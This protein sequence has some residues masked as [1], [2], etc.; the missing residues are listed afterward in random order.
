MS[1]PSVERVP[2]CR[3]PKRRLF[4]SRAGCK[5]KEQGFSLVE[6]MVVILIMG[7]L[8][9]FVAPSMH[10][11][12]F[13]AADIKAQAL[14]KSAANIVAGA[15]A[16][17][18]TYQMMQPNQLGC[19]PI[20]NCAPGNP[21]QWR[22]DGM[23]WVNYGNTGPT[24][25]SLPG[26]AFSST[27]ANTVTNPLPNDANAGNGSATPGVVSF[28]TWNSRGDGGL[29]TASAVAVTAGQPSNNCWFIVLHSAGGP[30][31]FGYFDAPCNNFGTCWQET[32]P[33]NR[34]TGC[35]YEGYSVEYDG[36]SGQ[37]SGTFPQDPKA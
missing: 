16:Q 3:V 24:D 19:A 35:S 5:S 13:E 25:T 7:I 34:P 18:G 8:M 12:S 20:A 10:G 4:G 26:I 30:D 22:A 21:L 28:F 33:Y 14:A 27:N 11:S 2:R 36:Y 17:T 37:A 32:P 31:V 6:L 15:Y 9:A 23:T 1:N 29:D